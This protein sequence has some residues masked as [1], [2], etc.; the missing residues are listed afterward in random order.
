MESDDCTARRLYELFVDLMNYWDQNHSLHTAW[1]KVFK[2]RYEGDEDWTLG[3]IQ[4]ILGS[5]LSEIRSDAQSLSPGMP[6]SVTLQ[7]FDQWARICFG[8]GFDAKSAGL[9]NI[10]RPAEHEINYLLIVANLVEYKLGSRR[11]E[12]EQLELLARQ[13]EDLL[14]E[15]RA[16]TILSP[17][18]RN[19]LIHSVT[20]VADAIR[21]YRI[22]G[23]SHLEKVSQVLAANVANQEASGGIKEKFFTFLRH[24]RLALHV[25]KGIS[26]LADGNLQGALESATKIIEAEVIKDDSDEES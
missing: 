23:S 19:R 9:G 6:P 25:G 14:K 11:I 2:S 24:I 5:M 26:Q 10:S 1:R 7:H 18:V 17:D 3:E 16:D 20:D 21:N 8:A 22:R 4:A 13:A 12:D 15:I